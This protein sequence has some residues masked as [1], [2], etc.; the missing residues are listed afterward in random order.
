MIN[1]ITQMDILDS[2]HDHAIDQDN[3][4]RLTGV[5]ET[6]SIHDF[7][8]GVANRSLVGEKTLV[9]WRYEHD[10][11]IGWDFMEAY[12]KFAFLRLVPVIPFCGLWE[13][14]LSAP[15]PPGR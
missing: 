14:K 9:I 1:K 2:N 6:S 3:E 4:R 8:A 13:L 12:K 15:N 11:D 7:S 10:L 5:N